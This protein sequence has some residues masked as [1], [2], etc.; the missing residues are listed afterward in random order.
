LRE[1]ARRHRARRATAVLSLALL[2]AFAAFRFWQ[3]LLSAQ[4]VWQDS[5]GYEAS[6]RNPFLSTGFWAGPRS[7]L[8]PLLWKLTGSPTSFVIVQTALAVLAWCF[9]AV[10]VGALARSWWR[11]LLAMTVVLA[12]ACTL[13]VTEWDW[14]VLSESLALA[15]LVAIFAFSIRFVRTTRLR[16]AAGLLGA[17][18][19][20]CLARDEDIWTIALI[21]IAF[22]A[23]AAV[24]WFSKRQRIRGLRPAQGLPP[25]Q[26]LHPG[27]TRR[28]GVRRLAA[29]GCALVVLAI[30]LEV[31]A[32]VSQRDVTNVTDILIVRIFPFP[33]R[34][35]WFAGHGMPDASL[36][37]LAAS[38]TAAVTGTAPVVAVD[39]QASEFA[40]LNSWITAHG[41]ATYALWLVEHP[42]FLIGAPFVKPPLTFNDASGD[43]GFYSSPD[44][45]ST[46]VLDQI[47]FPG[48]WGELATLVIAFGFAWRRSVWRR[49]E[50]WALVLLG[51]LGPVSMLLAWQGDGQEVTRHMV[52]GSA[53]TRLA[54]LL[55]LLVSALA[56]SP[57][58]GNAETGTEERRTE[59]T[60]SE[61]TGTEEL[62]TEELGTE[63]RGSDE[64]GTE[65][66]RPDRS[67][68]SAAPGALPRVPVSPR[69]HRSRHPKRPAFD[70]R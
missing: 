26:E 63:Q 58:T 69:G 18:T 36:I 49:K 60:G 59:E 3:A 4:G 53:E 22:L 6:A 37:D 46:S 34:V 12:F 68:S 20:F 62:G 51:V 23:A 48:L 54:V 55:L 52:E 43:I 67:G 44:R 40:A 35:A 19:A 57:E 41:P 21:G 15:S 9:L 61:E 42:G 50:V 8:A 39:L 11:R 56:P 33:D 25:A 16:D 24:M 31:P 66:G 5:Y 45:V 64:S 32:V 13:P 29:L 30:V 70:T 28:P 10:T 14:S 27:P 7:P 65:R 1:W 17:A 2:C 47:L 38:Q